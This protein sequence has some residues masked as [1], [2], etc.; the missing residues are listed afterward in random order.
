MLRREDSTYVPADV[1][2]GARLGV[3][4]EA[5]A[6]GPLENPGGGPD[7]VV[8]NGQVLAGAGGLV[9]LLVESPAGGHCNSGLL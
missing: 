3:T 6:D 8:G 5:E 9:L 2:S 1:A 4:A 7:A